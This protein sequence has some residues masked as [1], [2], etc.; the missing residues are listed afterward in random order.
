VS[1]AARKGEMKKIHAGALKKEELSYFT[2]C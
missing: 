2:K 1:I